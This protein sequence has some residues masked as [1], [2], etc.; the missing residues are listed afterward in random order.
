MELKSTLQDYT[1]AEFTQ[2][3]NKIR[4]VDAS[5]HEHNSLIDHFDRII[6]HPRGADLI[7]YRDKKNETLG[8]DEVSDIVYL[9]KQW[10]NDR[11]QLAYKD[12]TLPRPRQKPNDP[13]PQPTAQERARKT[14]TENLVKVQE[15]AN[16]I[17]NAKQDVENAFA[18]L[19]RLLINGE[20]KLDSP[21]GS[22]P[23]KAELALLEQKLESL[24]TAQHAVTRGVYN[25]NSLKLTVQFAKDDAQR[26]I[27][28][29]HLDRDL[30]VT[31]LKEITHS[32]DQYLASKPTLEKRQ[33]ELHIR[34]QARLDEIEAQLIRMGTRIGAGPL[35][36]ANIFC[37]TVS[38]IEAVSRVLTTYSDILDSFDIALPGLQRG[39]RSATS[40]LA[41]DASSEAV[42]QGAKYA[43]V[44]SFQFDKPGYGEPFAISVPLSELAPIEGRDWRYL[45][46]TAAE[47]DL[48]F[49][50]TSG[51]AAKRS[52]T[53]FQGLKEIKELANV[54]VVATN[55]LAVESGVKVYAAVWNADL[56]SYCFT[57]PGFPINTALWSAL[58]AP[59]T[60]GN[61]LP[62]RKRLSSPGSI[63]T[64][65]APVIE[66]IPVVEDLHFDDCIVV[67][68]EDSGIEPVYLMF[69]DAT[70]YAGAATGTGRQVGHSWLQFDAGDENLRIPSEIA[71]ELRG[72]VFKRFSSFRD[73]F[74]KTVANNP[75]LFAQFSPENLAAMKSGRGPIISTSSKPGELNRLKLSH[76]KSPEDGGDIYDMD[77][78]RV[79]ARS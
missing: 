10:H 29:G 7:F 31:I 46:A 68:P 18:N 79:S 66:E 49:R 16:Q 65:A 78:M 33:L 70:E 25:Y 58:S 36:E 37:T 53:L 40:G 77:N 26:S 47:V 38:D 73:T 20:V 56:N 43:S 23:E 13:T 35:K 42:E 11:G 2:L 61:V 48:A 9:V 6:Q 52:G 75:R 72:H 24:E 17:N 3:L 63:G 50:L 32:S 45:A 44:L 15:I 34:A 19:E 62:L 39:I 59:V 41:W 22:L 51:V 30:Q 8:L 12:D 1:Q 21:V 27:S 57:R 64:D 54:Y 5:N 71:D 4:N 67:F 74:W 28:Y 55:S 14:S 60:Q 69:K 76:F